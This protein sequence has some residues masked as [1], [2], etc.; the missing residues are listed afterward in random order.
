M[1]LVRAVERINDEIEKW[2]RDNWKNSQNQALNL[3][4]GY[5]DEHQLND[6]EFIESIVLQIKQFVFENKV[7]VQDASSSCDVIKMTRIGYIKHF[8]LQKCSE[9]LFLVDQFMML[10]VYYSLQHVCNQARQR[11]KEANRSEGTDENIHRSV[12]DIF[13][14][15]QLCLEDIRKDLDYELV[16]NGYLKLSMPRG[17]FV[18]E[19]KLAQYHQMVIDYFEFYMEINKKR[20]GIQDCLLVIYVDANHLTIALLRYAVDY[21]LPHIISESGNWKR[22]TAYLKC[23]K[24]IEHAQALFSQNGNSTESCQLLLDC[25][26]KMQKQADDERSVLSSCAGYTQQFD[27]YCERSHGKV[28]HALENLE[29][30]VK[31]SDVAEKGKGKEKG[32]AQEQMTKKV[33][34]SKHANCRFT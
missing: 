34:Y 16:K 20:D 5:F 29:E 17:P 8:L 30:D 2:L 13:S 28:L 6:Y 26:H 4:P 15:S 25:I 3:K 31:M 10:Y 11:F 19:A 9:H 32:A 33:L 1:F 23:Q 14:S 22:S 24:I 7:R 12:M 21:V 27:V 18:C